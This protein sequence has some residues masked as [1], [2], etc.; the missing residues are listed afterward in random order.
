MIAIG[1][2]IWCGRPSLVFVVA[3]DSP[4]IPNLEIRSYTRNIGKVTPM[5]DAIGKGEGP[6]SNQQLGIRHSSVSPEDLII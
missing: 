6:T 1:R 2:Q 3:S 4:S 5:A